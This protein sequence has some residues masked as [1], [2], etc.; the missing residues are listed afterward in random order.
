MKIVTL[1][2]IKGGVGKTTL[3]YNW[4]EDLARKGKSVLF[5]D[6]D[7][8]CNL[9]QTYNTFESEGTVA[10]IFR[11][12]GDVTIHHIKNNVDLIPGYIRLD[13]I[14]KDLETKSYKDMLLYMWLEDNYESKNLG[15]YDYIIIDCH[16]DFST[17]TRNAVIV[18]HAV[19]SPVIPSEH[20]YHA[21]FNLKERLEEL[22]AETFDYKTR[23]SFV[24]AKLF[25]VGNMIKHNTKSSK[26]L[27]EAL[28][29]EDDVIGFIP[30]KE[31]FNR[32]TMDKVS[33]PEMKE[34]KVIYQHNKKFFD[35][36][37]VT[38][39]EITAKL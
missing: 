36:L 1:A 14:E 20:G 11:Q 24:T 30:Q 21:K 34:D 19:I 5:I 32:S 25:F 22:K 9:T 2:A 17:A 29:E 12:K 18:S 38:F 4:G 26:E 23:E 35:D 3:A 27:I 6:L 31:L 37:D 7:H 33:L 15:Q 10:N 16:P 28:A 39:E 13:N 8:Q